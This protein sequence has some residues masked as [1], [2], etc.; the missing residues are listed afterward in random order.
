MRIA[1]ELV[2]SILK[3]FVKD[4]EGKTDSKIQVL[5]EVEDDNFRAL[6][7]ILHAG[8]WSILESRGDVSLFKD[9][10]LL[11][12]YK[13]ELENQ[14]RKKIQESQQQL[15]SSIAIFQS[16]TTFSLN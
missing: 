10:S 9:M 7:F 2:E 1:E 13:E 6:F 11:R 3:S 8:E 12:R 4:V 5:V 14:V 16:V 15:P